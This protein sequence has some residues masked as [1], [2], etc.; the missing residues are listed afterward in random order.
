MKGKILYSIIGVL[1]AVA[2]I[3]PFI[4]KCPST[5]ACHTASL[6][7]AGIGLVIVA[8][9]VI[10]PFIK[11]VKNPVVSALLLAGGIGTFAVP[12]IFR[13]CPSMNMACRNLMTPSL[14]VL[15]A[16]IMI[17]SLTLLVR[18]MVAKRT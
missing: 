18:G 14:T 1:G 10:F 13:L 8:I 17:L 5:M 4:G 2:A 7:A 11:N 15:G 9:I 16:A 6:A 12:R 3:V